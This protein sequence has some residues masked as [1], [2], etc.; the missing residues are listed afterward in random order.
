MNKF[1]PILLL[2]VSAPVFAT[3]FYVGQGV[4]EMPPRAERRGDR[5]RDRAIRFRVG[6]S[7]L[8][9]EAGENYVGPARIESLLDGIDHQLEYRA[10]DGGHGILV[11]V[12]PADGADDVRVRTIIS[13]LVWGFEGFVSSSGLPGPGDVHYDLCREQAL[14][15][16]RENAESTAEITGLRLGRV[17]RVSHYFDPASNSVRAEIRFELE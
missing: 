4:C 11:S 5:N 14:R 2:L 3:Q 6:A 17:S 8:M 1:L 15:Q 12:T 7:A 10:I 9:D 13:S 16:A